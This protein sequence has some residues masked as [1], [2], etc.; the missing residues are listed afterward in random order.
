MSV[1]GAPSCSLQRGYCVRDDDDWNMTKRDV[2]EEH[3][4]WCHLVVYSAVHNLEVSLH[5]QVPT[6]RTKLQKVRKTTRPRISYA[7]NFSHESIKLCCQ[8][9]ITRI[10]R[11]LVNTYFGSYMSTGVVRCRR[12]ERV[13]KSD[14]NIHLT[15]TQRYAFPTV[16]H[17]TVGAV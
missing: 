1:H 9:H 7:R 4:Y 17:C 14:K 6:N 10:Q 13:S 11:T 12:L 15:L 2:V 5:E 16:F 8:V 3:L